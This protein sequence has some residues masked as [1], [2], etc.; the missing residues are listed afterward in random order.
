MRR[1]I[2]G[3]LDGDRLKRGEFTEGAV[4]ILG[5]LV[6]GKVT[7]PVKAPNTLKSLGA[8]PEVE[9]NIIQTSRTK[10][11]LSSDKT[12]VPE[13]KPKVLDPKDVHP[14]NVR[15]TKGENEAS[16]ILSE[17]GY[18]VEQLA[19]KVKGKIQGVKK[20]DLKIEGKIFDAYT[21]SE[22]KNVRGVWFE[23]NKKI[24]K[25]QA[26]RF[27]VNM[28]ESKLTL[29]Q[30]TKQF[31]DFPMEKLKEVILVKNGKVTHFFPFDK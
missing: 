14:D 11:S 18:K 30:L 27:V 10:P 28:N 22:T 25:G 26:D 20:P 23:L 6:I 17:N 4:T 7:S 29:E 3:K 2:N 16:R 15:G 21:P 1:D 12:R 5:P 19:D 9:A 13:G 31:K 24:Q 8:L